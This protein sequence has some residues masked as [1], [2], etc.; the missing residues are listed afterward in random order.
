MDDL[1]ILH[2]QILDYFGSHSFTCSSCETQEWLFRESSDISD[3]AIYCSE[4]C[5]TQPPKC[6]TMSVKVTILR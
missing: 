4:W 6:H 5:D 2:V 1:G 3:F